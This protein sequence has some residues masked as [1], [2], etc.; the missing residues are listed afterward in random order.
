MNPD[1]TP[2]EGIPE[3]TP[4]SPDLAQGLR[5]PECQGQGFVLTIV[6]LNEDGYLDHASASPCPLCKTARTVT[7]ATFRHWHATRSGRP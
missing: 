3:D 4:T 7:R 2:P 5:C 6:E 1:D